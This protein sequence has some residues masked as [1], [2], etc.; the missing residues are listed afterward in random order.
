MF[1][2][3]VNAVFLIACLCVI[4]SGSMYVTKEVRMRRAMASRQHIDVGQTLNVPEALGKTTLMMELSDTCPHCI[5]NQPLYRELSAL[6]QVSNGKVQVA[7][8]MTAKKQQDAQNF[9]TRNGIP[10]K[11]LVGEPGHKFSFP[12]V[13]T[14][15]ILMLDKTGK[16]LH[17]WVGELHGKNQQDFLNGLHRPTATTADRT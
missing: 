3:F 8:V 14:P 17:K 11:L 12:L 4:V 6:P 9:A 15:T 7:T 1:D 16:V 2:K 10:G 5:A 13:A